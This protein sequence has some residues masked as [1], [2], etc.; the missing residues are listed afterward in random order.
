[1]RAGGGDGGGRG[2]LRALSEARGEPG[3]EKKTHT[4]RE[5]EREK[6]RRDH[7]HTILK[8]TRGE[9]REKKERKKGALLSLRAPRRY[10]VR[11]GGGERQ[12][13][14]RSARSRKRGAAGPGEGL[15][16]APG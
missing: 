1:M 9:E 12:A 15:L 13:A 3:G 7:N 6:R 16:H 5:R 14:E 11:A 10:N 4:H 2:A 8:C